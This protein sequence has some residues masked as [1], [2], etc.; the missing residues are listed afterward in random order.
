[1]TIYLEDPFAQQSRAYDVKVDGNGTFLYPNTDSEAVFL[2]QMTNPG[3]VIFRFDNGF[4][5]GLTS[6]NFNP[7]LNSLITSYKI[8]VLDLTKPALI[9]QIPIDPD[10]LEYT[11]WN[12]NV[13]TDQTIS[14]FDM[15]KVEAGKAKYEKMAEENMAKLLGVSYDTYEWIIFGTEGV[16][17][18]SGAIGSDGFGAAEA[19][20]PFVVDASQRI[21][22][23]FIDRWVSEGKMTQQAADFLKAT[24]R[25]T[26]A[27]VTFPDPAHDFST[28]DA[29]QLITS[30]Y[31]GTAPL[32]EGFTETGLNGTQQVRT[33]WSLDNETVTILMSSRDIPLAEVTS[34]VTST[35]LVHFETAGQTTGVS[36]DFQNITGTGPVTVRMFNS[37]SENA[38]FITNQPSYISPYHWTI[39]QSGLSSV[40][41][42]VRFKLSDFDSTITNPTAI[43]VYSRSSIGSGIFNSLPTSYDAANSEIVANVSGF[44]E[45]VFASNGTVNGITQR[46]EGLPSS[47][48][49]SQNF[50][51]PFNPSTTIQYA[52]PKS[53]EVTLIVYNIL[54]QHVATLVNETQG[55]GYHEAKFDGTALASGVYFYRIQAGSFVQT[56]KLLLLR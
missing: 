7:I 1:L 46:I 56:K 39:T 51:N 24:T 22:E 36:I 23:V 14:Q 6:R 2:Y 11:R 49:L 26:G 34:N 43:T 19:C 13:N 41:A 55:A 53:S 15:V 20:A 27:L 28:F 18:V 35:G 12:Q 50:P 4:Q 42:Q 29:M 45:F 3:T 21:L 44:S 17:C 9:S 52:L 10:M 47:F 38:G 48:T 31:D 16:A 8:T 30:I 5:F 33:T 37:P 40:S 25:L 54:G 32:I